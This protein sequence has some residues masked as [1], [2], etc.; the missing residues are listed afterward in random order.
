ME[1]LFLMNYF[2]G[3]SKDV[4]LVSPYEQVNGVADRTMNED[5]VLFSSI[6]I[7]HYYLSKEINLIVRRKIS[8][9]CTEIMF[10]H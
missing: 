4:F 10:N 9:E 2:T 3:S 8:S 5:N 7:G 1:I 6:Y